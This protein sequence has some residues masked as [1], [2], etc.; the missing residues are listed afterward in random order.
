MSSRHR[1]V[2]VACLLVLVFAVASQTGSRHATPSP[3]TLVGTGKSDI[4]PA[5]H[6]PSPTPRP[7]N[8]P[9]PTATP[10]PRPPVVGI[11]P[12]HGGEDLGACHVDAEGHLILTE[13]EANLGIALHLR[14]ELESRGIEV[15]LTR[16]GD[17]GL[18]EAGEDINLDGT[19]DYVDELQARLDVIN[20]ADVD[21][22]LSI[23]QNAFYYGSALA[24]DVGGTVTYF[25]DA[26]RFSDESLRFAGLVQE[27]IVS[28][29]AGIGYDS[30]DR[31]VRVDS[32]LN[33]PDEPVKHL[34]VLGPETPRLQRPSQMPGVLSETLFITHDEE[35]QLLHDDAVRQ[36]LAVAYADAIQAYLQGLD[37][38][39]P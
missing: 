8:M 2:F 16:D 21:L 6:A 23:H 3:E 37:R 9:V 33:D 28:A 5:Q 1:T 15:V 17:Y 20:E 38:L 10:T 39:T 34:I 14:D 31:G 19:V 24:R 27:A 26:R 7:T 12:G 32:E 18:N 25:C 22:L 4:D 30:P 11:D 29:L 35:V 36:R 13:S